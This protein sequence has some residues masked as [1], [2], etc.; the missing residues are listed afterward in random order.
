M[1]SAIEKKVAVSERGL[2]CPCEVEAPWRELVVTAL[3]TPWSEARCLR[4]PLAGAG[5]HCLRQVVVAA[6]HQRCTLFPTPADA[7][8]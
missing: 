6:L 4:H 2:C 5:D 7:R 1:K 3:G 8:T